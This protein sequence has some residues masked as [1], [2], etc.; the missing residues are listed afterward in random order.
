MKTTIAT[1]TPIGGSLHP[2]VRWIALNVKL[3]LEWFDCIAADH[4]IA[5]TGG[6]Y[7]QHAENMNSHFERREIILKQYPPNDQ[8]QARRTYGSRLQDQRQPALPA[9]TGSVSNLLKFSSGPL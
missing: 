4:V 5:E 6:T 8:A 2:V 7:E 9:A 1:E 3:A